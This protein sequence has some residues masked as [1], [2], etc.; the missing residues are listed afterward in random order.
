MHRSPVARPSSCFHSESLV[1]NCGGTDHDAASSG[2]RQPGKGWLITQVLRD[3]SFWPLF[4]SAWLNLCSWST[5]TIQKRHQ[6]ALVH[7]PVSS[8]F[9]KLIKKKKSSS[10]EMISNNSRL[11][12]ERCSAMLCEGRDIVPSLWG[13][14][15]GSTKTLPVTTSCI[16]GNPVSEILYD[17]DS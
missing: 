9:Q 10:L 7:S 14:A 16:S 5:E 3:T 13:N 12:P 4:R 6:I 2:Q 8:Y 11:K 17:C 15:S 1:R